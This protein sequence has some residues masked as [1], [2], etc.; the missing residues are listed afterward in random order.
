[1]RLFPRPKSR[2][3]QGPSVVSIQKWLKDDSWHRTFALKVRFWHSLMNCHQ[4]NEL[5]CKV[6]FFLL[7]TLIFC[8]ISCFLESRQLVWWKV[9]IRYHVHRVDVHR[10]HVYGVWRLS[11][12]VWCIRVVWS[13]YW[14]MNFTWLLTIF[15]NS[16]FHHIEAF[17]SNIFPTIFNCRD[18]LYSSN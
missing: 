17:T 14:V 10:V 11:R 7:S 18:S 3:R 2:I 5:P 9:N 6:S 16:T 13:Q 12:T 15:H 8:P 4:L 1:M